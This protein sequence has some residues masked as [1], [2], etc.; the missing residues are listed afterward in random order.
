MESLKKITPLFLLLLSL[1]GVACAQKKITE[2]VVTYTVSYEL[3]AD[4]QQ[5]ADMLPKE[6]S[7]YFRGDSSAAIVDQG[8][9]VIKGVSVFKT[10]YHCLIINIAAAGKKIVVVMTPDEV[11]QEKAG[12]PQFTGKKGTEKQV[13]AGYNC[14]K[15]IV[16]DPKTS[17]SYDE[18]ITNDIDIPATSV[19][20]AV[21]TFGGVPIKFVTFNN[22]VKINAIVKEIKAQPVPAGFF[23]ASKDYESMSYT[24][25]KAM[26]GN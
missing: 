10:D 21:T 16:T 12:M 7:C 2:G 1:T 11:A 22:G 18:W 15:T 6:I 5:Y 8:A 26:S 14:I 23:T 3:P 4:R 9:A 13:V 17:I 20:K 25:L 24:A 19:S